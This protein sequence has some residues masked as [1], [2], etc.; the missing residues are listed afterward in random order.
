MFTDNGPQ[1]LEYNVR[2]GDPE[3]QPL[4]MRLQTDLAEILLACVEGRLSQ[5]DVVSD[6]RSNPG[7]GHGRRGL[8]RLPIPRAM[9]IT[10][11]DEA[12]ALDGVKVFQAG[13]RL[14]NGALVTS[15]GPGALRHRPGR[16][17]LAAAKEQAYRAVE[18]I[19]FD[20]S[21]YRRDIGDKGLK[22]LG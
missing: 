10:G 12:E 22:R 14:D 4:L 19:H 9:P 15:G 2:F 3:C 11:I 1:V 18:K 17:A 8:S 21:Y 16:R 7:R 13:T 5:V 6:P 20:N